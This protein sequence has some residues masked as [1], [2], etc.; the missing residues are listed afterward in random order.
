MTEY[1]PS[2]NSR[3]FIIDS[4]GRLLAY[5]ANI[6]TVDEKA[7]K[8]DAISVI[9]TSVNDTVI[10]QLS[11][12]IE[13]KFLSD[14]T[15]YTT[16]RLERVGLED[17]MWTYSVHKLVVP[18]DLYLYIVG[19]IPREDYFAIDDAQRRSS[20]LCWQLSLWCLELLRNNACL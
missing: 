19:A 12:V 2:E 20:S 5:N 14:S 4:I 6:S 15:Y 3:V 13:D 11:R 17:G 18:S 9:A 10:S 8:I 1:T 7:T 16:E